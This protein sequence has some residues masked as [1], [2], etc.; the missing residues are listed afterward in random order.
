M[1]SPKPFRVQSLLVAALLMGC[2]AIHAQPRYTLTDLGATTDP[3]ALTSGIAINARGQVLIAELGRQ[4][5][6]LHTPGSRPLDLG[7][8]V[9]GVRLPG[10]TYHV[11]VQGLKT[12]A[13]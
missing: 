10:Y 8:V 2:S 4:T 1:T 9:P 3:G 12:P 5:A 7:T 13:R 6:W 11:N